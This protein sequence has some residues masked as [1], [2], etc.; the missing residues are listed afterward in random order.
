MANGAM[1]RDARFVRNTYLLT[2]AN[3]TPQ[4]HAYTVTVS[5]LPQARTAPEAPIIV[6]ARDS[7]TASVSVAVPSG[8][9]RAGSRAAIRLI[10]Q[11]GGQRT[12]VETLF[13]TPQ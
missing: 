2:I 13:Y 5:G 8:A 9:A 3:G 12:T 10:L 6:G 11:G 1:S 4:A 7:G